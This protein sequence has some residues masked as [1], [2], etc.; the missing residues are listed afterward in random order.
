MHQPGIWSW[1]RVVLPLGRSYGEVFQFPSS[2]A[3]RSRRSGLT[4]FSVRC[5][6]F[7]NHFSWWRGAVLW[8]FSVMSSGRPVRWALQAVLLGC[9]ARPRLCRIFSAL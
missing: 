3:G 5:D 9:V 6:G 8:V 4:V 7:F 1:K 2:T